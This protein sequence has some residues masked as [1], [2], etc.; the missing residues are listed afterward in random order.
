MPILI[1]T[2]RTLKDYWFVVVQTCL[3]TF[4]SFAPFANTQALAE[5]T[6]VS[7]TTIRVGSVLDLVSDSSEL[8]IGMKAGIEAA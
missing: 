1:Q 4:L 6:G 7:N 8:G 3:F 2:I 5:E